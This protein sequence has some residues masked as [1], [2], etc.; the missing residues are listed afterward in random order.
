MVTDAGE[1]TKRQKGEKKL[2]REEPPALVMEI[3]HDAKELQLFSLE[4]EP[5]EEQKQALK[6]NKLDA[7]HGQWLIL[8]TNSC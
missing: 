6:D 4:P 8:G 7:L 3:L 2:D 5:T 1:I